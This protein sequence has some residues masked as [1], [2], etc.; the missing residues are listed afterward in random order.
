[1]TAS[2]RPDMAGYMGLPLAAW[3]V[4]S[5]GTGIG[6]G[7]RVGA[8]RSSLES[9]VE[10]LSS[11]PVPSARPQ[12]CVGSCARTM[13]AAYWFRS[14]PFHELTRSCTARG[15]KIVMTVGAAPVQIFALSWLALSWLGPGIL[16]YA[17]SGS[18]PAGLSEPTDPTPFVATITV[19]V[20]SQLGCNSCGGDR[21]LKVG[22]S[23][24]TSLLQN[25]RQA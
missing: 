21:Q 5:R 16:Q 6:A 4:G 17:G 11:C 22:W 15:N 3:C 25:V 7:R 13:I 23:P 19:R 20:S 1:M 12:H 8:F 14:C 24:C 18:Q 9:A 10:N 2:I